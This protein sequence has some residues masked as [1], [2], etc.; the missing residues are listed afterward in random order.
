M[1][2]MEFNSGNAGSHS[3]VLIISI[4][5]FTNQSYNQRPSC[6]I[7]GKTGHVAWIAITAWI[8]PI[9]A[10]NLHPNWQQWQQPQ[11]LNTQISPIGFLTQEQQITSLLI[12][13]PFL[14]IKTMLVVILLLLVMVM[15][16]QSL[17]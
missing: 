10:N 9:K 4:Q 15:H 5:F 2:E 11:M 6:Q 13:Q 12:S 1:V 14:I 3:M 7:C 17:I 16:F 8:M